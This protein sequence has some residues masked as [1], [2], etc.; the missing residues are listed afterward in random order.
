MTDRDQDTSTRQH[1]AFSQ[2]FGDLDEP[3]PVYAHVPGVD[4]IV[5]LA[6][7]AIAA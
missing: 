2:L 1:M 4:R 7:D 6:D 5:M 3:V